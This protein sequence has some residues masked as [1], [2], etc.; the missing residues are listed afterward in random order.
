MSQKECAQRLKEAD[1]SVLSSLIECG[2]AV[3]L[4]AMAAGLPV[5]ATAWGGPL[6]Y[7]DE[8]CGILVQ[9]DSREAL[10]SGFA[11]AIVKLARSTSLRD[12]MG[13]TG[14][15]RART[16]Y[17]WERRI[18]RIEELYASVLPAS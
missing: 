18:D 15:D 10:V 1:V 6:D 4:E 17:D 7:L 16:H 8:T 5:I 3:I 13:R 14:Y 9:P 11:D 2:G 12:A